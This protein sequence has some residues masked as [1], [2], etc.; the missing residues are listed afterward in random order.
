MPPIRPLPAVVIHIHTQMAGLGCDETL[1]QA[2]LSVLI[3]SLDRQTVSTILG[4]L[5]GLNL[6]YLSIVFL[7]NF[8][9][10]ASGHGFFFY[11]WQLVRRS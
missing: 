2:K 8:A 7:I 4:I 5:L 10:K 11:D 3:G 1:Q 9:F 6:G